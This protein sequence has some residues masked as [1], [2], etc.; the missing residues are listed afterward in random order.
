MSV[1]TVQFEFDNS[2]VRD[3][4]GLF[5][6]WQPQ[7]VRDPSVIV[8]NEALARELG[9]DPAALASPE[10]VQIL[11]GNAVPPGAASVA[12]AYAGHQFGG[13]SPRLG[14]GRA[15]LLGEIIDTHGRR[16]DLHLKGSGRTTY[17]RGADGRAALGP[18]LREYIVGEGMYG[19][20]IPTTRA[21]SV[22]FTGEHIAR[23]TGLVPGGVLLRVAASHLR[24]G[25]FQYARAHTD[26]TLLRR[27]AD[28]AIA[29]HHP[30]AAT[31]PNPYAALLRGVLEAQASLVASWMSVGFVHGVLNTDNVT[32]SGETID[33]GPC[34]FLDGFDPASVFSSIDQNG[35]YAYQNQPAITLWNLTRF[36][37]ALLPLLDEDDDKAV[38]LAKAEL[39]GFGA[40]FEKRWLTTMLAKIGLP[41]GAGDDLHLVQGLLGVLAG[42]RADW[43]GSFRALADVLRGEDPAASFF[44]PDPVRAWVTDW[45]EALRAALIVP[46]AAAAAMDRVNPIYI[47]RNHLVEAALSAAEAEDFAPLH[48]LIDAISHPYDRRPH[49][50]AYAQPAPDTFG[51]YRTFCGT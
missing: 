43:T 48:S 42:Q 51:P 19:L 32:I 25:S 37:E 31:D 5:T 46:E 40:V 27:L 45:H 7:A 30:T 20:G 36:A 47:P 26:E 28:H 34:A 41:R 50:D 23:D 2:F 11:A 35:R 1:A 39:E 33:Y 18:M 24:V 16:R 8:L 21:L 38:E 6:P 9:L 29:R 17:S 12:Q 10:G 22:V 3:L 49:L 14:D 4:P 15:F 13:Y 44:E